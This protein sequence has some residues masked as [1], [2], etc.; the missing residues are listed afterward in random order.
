MLAT[1]IFQAIDMRN[2]KRKLKVL[3]LLE[4]LENRVTPA[5][6]TVPLDPN[7]D[8]FG[9]QIGT[10]QAYGDDSRTTFG[11]FDTGAS[12]VTFS[13]D[14]ADLFDALG[15][16]IPIKVPDG[17][18]AG[19]IGGSITGDV[20]Q[21]GTILA[22]GMH[23]ETLTFDNLGFPNFS[24]N[25]DS[26]AAST[27]GI[28]SFVGSQTGSPDLPTITGTPILHPSTTNPAGLA[29]RID[30]Q[31]VST[32]YSFFIPGLILTEPDLNFVTPGT[33]LQ[34]GAGLTDPVYIPM[35]T[36]GGDT[37]ANP[38][39]DI[40][41]SPS[42]MQNNVSV[43]YT[44]TSGTTAE[45]DNNHFLLDTGSQ[46]TVISTALAASLG[47][48]LNNPQ[49]TIDVGGVG[50]TETVP[51]FTIDKLEVPTTDPNTFVDFTNVPVYVLDVAPGVDGLLGMNL[52]DTASTMLYD[53][54]NPT[55]ATLGVT[56]FT[57]PNRGLDDST[58][59]GLDLLN[60]SF[61][62]L[63]GGAI[64]GA[65]SNFIGFRSTGLTLLPTANFTPV[66]P[67]VRSSAVTSV[68]FS[69]SEPMPTTSVSLSNLQ[70][71]LNGT[72]VNLQG[73]TL[74]P[75][76]DQMH[77]TIGNLTGLTGASGTYSLKVGASG[78]TIKDFNG[79]SMASAASTSWTTVTIDHFAMVPTTTTATAGAS[80]AVLIFA[81]DAS[82]NTVNFNGNVAVTSNDPL[83]TNEGTVA[84]SGGVGITTVSLDTATQ[85]GWTLQVTAGSLTS[86]S[87][88]IIVSPG[89]ATS[90]VLTTP[91][92][93]TTGSPFSVNVRAQDHFGN[94]ASG[95]SGTVKLTSTDTA[96]ATFST[97]K[98]SSSDA[99]SHVFTS[100]VTLNTQGTQTISAID[101]SASNPAI[102]GT[103]SGITTRGL[104]IS[105]F[106]PTATGFSVSFS[107]AILPPD[108]T[109]YGPTLGTAKDVT[110]IGAHVG[111]IHGSL[112]VNS[113]GTSLTFNATSSYLLEKNSAA[114]PATVSA[115]LPD[116]TYTVTLLTAKGSNG[117][118]DAA[119]EGLDGLS[120][121]GHA[122]FVTTFTTNYQHNANPALSLP[123]MARGPDSNAPI[124]L[125]NDSASGIPITLY[126]AVNVTD[127]SFTLAY[128][129]ALFTITGT[130]PEN[131]S[132]ATD[133]NAT[134]TFSANAGG[135]ATFTYHDVTPQSGTLILGDIVAF[136]PSSAKN[137][138]Q[139][140]ELLQ[141]GNIIVN[142]G[143][144]TGTVP[145]AAVHVN[146][147]FG[148]VNADGNID[149]IDTLTA[150][151]VAIGKAT[152]FNAYQQLDPVIIG[153]VAGD[154]TVDA[155]DVTALDLYA[156]KLHP[157]Q[158]P[159]PPGLAV[160]S[161]FAADPT[162]SLVS[163]EGS[164]VSGR[165]NS[166]LTTNLSLS[167]TIDHPHPEGSTGLT[168]AVLAL[169][170]DPAMLSVSAD[171]ITL[172]SLPKQGS[173]WQISSTVDQ[174]TGQIGITIFSLTPITDAS[175]GSLVNI[176]FQLAQGERRGV[177]PPLQSTTL[178]QLVNA[179]T[180]LGERFATMVADSLGTMILS[181]GADQ[182][183]VPTNVG[184]D[185]NRDIS[186]QAST[187]ISA[188][189]ASAPTSDTPL[190]VQSVDVPPE[191][192]ENLTPPTG[193]VM[194]GIVP[195]MSGFEPVADAR[196]GQTIYLSAW[197]VIDT[198][199][200]LK[201][202]L[203]AG[204]DVIFVSADSQAADQPPESSRLDAVD[205]VFAEWAIDWNEWDV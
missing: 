93:A 156:A 8:Q 104:T 188:E 124:K 175:G 15:T 159:V 9:D 34:G 22:A 64:P 197:P 25:F 11:I 134:L 168:E 136:V 200:S 7:L 166:P 198:S 13:P 36:F 92:T 116:D 84:L 130:V 161:P 73:A 143:A 31:G 109:L 19:G 74:T 158:I 59:L 153:D 50:G 201:A 152:G 21:P 52:F 56:F 112:V 47:L 5:N 182:I 192:A 128:N 199:L 137:L 16:P 35:G 42:P 54:Y 183:P 193:Q 176:A 30:T 75:A 78:P 48:D 23:A 68:T 205:K 102:I 66:S 55:G 90:F 17:A 110:L 144:V 131:N 179:A 190:I 142:T 77:W 61:G 125:P 157:P 33:K 145:T 14:D 118:Q 189:S 160:I 60:S 204:M 164:V 38:G 57:D 141:L 196:G 106:V 24:A 103:S 58:E 129:P 39:N 28:Q 96:L 87:G 85:T 12:A 123:D 63:L 163:G 89:A 150:N 154:L 114:T 140:K 105:G 155:G 194:I 171:D 70:L 2:R 72:N 187:K 148:D 111:P 88:P 149:G 95:Y 83:I 6:V 20:S 139:V 127:V 43:F 69:F 119:G 100:A 120:N 115:V 191:A 195:P 49:T 99:G 107:K 71:T 37:F 186:A 53:P 202:P 126:N 27:P 3:L 146:A 67:S 29:A 177:S 147:Y 4:E 82:N 65:N 18:G 173:G 121:A 98:F 122:N 46:L 108:L 181:P 81:K 32:D 184:Y 178:I 117:F 94:T 203:A 97:Y 41:E 26:T 174:A 51:G 10:V 162:L 40:T 169:T 62:D 44:P 185:S 80:F 132:Q 1:S 172:G 180:P 135:V 151:Q 76:K 113:T 91:S 86:T 167:V 79:V 138:Y 101:T 133:P 45:S 165:N 170:Y